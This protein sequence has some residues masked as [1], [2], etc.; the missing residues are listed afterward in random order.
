M[1]TDTTHIAS[2]G[3]ARATVQPGSPSI[4]RATARASRSA[5]QWRLLVLWLVL[6]LAPAIVAALPVWQLLATNLDYSVHAA[7]LAQRLDMVA[8]ADLGAGQLRYGAAIGN[9]QIVA[10]VL[11]LLLSPLL[12]GITISAA[13]APRQLGFGGL[14][15]GGVQEYGRLLRMLLWSV[16]P[17]GLAAI[18]AGIAL[19]AAHKSGEAASLAADADRAD[20]WGMIAAGL[21]MLVALATLDAGRAVLAADLRR[22]SAVVAWWHGC[23]L[24]AR[25]PLAGFGIYAGIS[26]VGLALAA[27]LAVA[28][29]NVP[30]L[31]LGGFFGALALA[32]LAVAAV[33]WMRSARL[34]A[35]ME[36]A[37]VYRRP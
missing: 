22:K 3:V 5:L 2:P 27:L 23:R 1:M 8:L 12:T 32:Q 21:V 26:A 18:V 11:T 13:R 28:R 6:L 10:I 9:G 14:A 31:G 20:M 25:R 29:I 7:E 17:L 34:I 19:K 24:L 36:L 37:R 4:L 16:V 35:L 33:A 15:A 30:A